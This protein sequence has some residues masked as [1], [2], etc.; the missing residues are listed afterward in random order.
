MKLLLK[1]LRNKKIEAIHKEIDSLKKSVK[2]A[3][4]QFLLN[5]KGN[6]KFNFLITETDHTMGTKV[7]IKKRER[8]LEVLLSKA[9]KQQ[10][11]RYLEKEFCN[12]FRKKHLSSKYR[13]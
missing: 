1:G 13:Q 3:K 9:N 7:R 11:T 12:I 8:H 2:V 6:W 5:K 4:F 10:V